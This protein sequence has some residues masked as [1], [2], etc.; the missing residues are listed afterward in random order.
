[1]ISTQEASYL[2][3]RIQARRAERDRVREAHE[4]ARRASE[5]ALRNLNEKRRELLAALG[6]AHLMP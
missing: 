3:G 4:E 6:L 2:L 1:M 5:E